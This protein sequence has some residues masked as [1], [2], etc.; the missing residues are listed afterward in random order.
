MFCLTYFNPV[1][2]DKIKS[3]SGLNSYRIRAKEWCEKTNAIGIQ[4][5]AG[6]YGGTYAHKDITFEFGR[7]SGK[8]VSDHLPIIIDIG[9]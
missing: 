3:Q 7:G 9:L 8:E 6:R 1:E 2:F 4:A 5:C